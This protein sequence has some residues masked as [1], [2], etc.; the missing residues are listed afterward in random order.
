M[1]RARP[2]IDSDRQANPRT[3]EQYGSLSNVEYRYLRDQTRTFTH[4][5]TWMPGGGPVVYRKTKV[6][7]SRTS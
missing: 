5:A 7:F 4:L 6:T 2:V 3:E 1:A